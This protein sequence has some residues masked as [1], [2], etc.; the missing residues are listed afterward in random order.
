M[1][2]NAFFL[3][4][5]LPLIMAFQP[6]PLSSIH[7]EVGEDAGF[8][9]KFQRAMEEMDSAAREIKRAT[10]PLKALSFIPKIGSTLSGGVSELINAE[11][12]KQ[13]KE[14]LYKNIVGAID[15]SHAEQQL[16][17]VQAILSTISQ[18]FSMLKEGNI[19]NSEIGTKI[20]IIEN[21]LLNVMNTYSLRNS[22]FRKY[23]QLTISQF[24]SI[25]VLSILFEA[26]Y[27]SFHGHEYVG[28]STFIGCR[29]Q[30][31]ME[32]YRN[33][34][35]IRRLNAKNFREAELPALYGL[36]FDAD[37]EGHITSLVL[38]A[39]YNPQQNVCFR[40]K[41]AGRCAVSVIYTHLNPM[42]GDVSDRA[43]TMEYKWELRNRIKSAYD[44]TKNTLNEICPQQLRERRKSTGFGWVLLGFITAYG[45]TLDNGKICDRF[46]VFRTKSSGCDLFVEFQVDSVSKY[47]TTV[48]EID[49][50]PINFN[51]VYESEKFSKQQSFTLQLLDKDK[52]KV[53]TLITV[54][55]SIEDLAG[56]SGQVWK[57]ASGK[58]YFDVFVHWI[59]EYEDQQ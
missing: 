31:L 48:H 26:L 58:N 51:A 2:C 41:D 24:A 16:L 17:G 32:D 38:Q 8:G 20:Q 56:K 39:D 57:S 49:N 45:E 14:A 23:P 12:Q 53:D 15:Q 30:D 37:V 19:D 54:S 21:E 9:E 44:M 25:A 22:V 11:I 28:K 35:V 10:I 27:K 3:I 13:W 34:H 29:L 5:A 59:E 18:Q 50:S 4:V 40:K 36:S 7:I 6:V 55:G 46:P 47:L 1:K 33:V 43:C 52:R 42:C